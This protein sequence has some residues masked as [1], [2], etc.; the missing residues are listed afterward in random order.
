MLTEETVL[1]LAPNATFQPLG[2]N[3][4]AVVLMV[5]SGQLYTCND[6]TVALLQVLDGKRNFG[7]LIDAMLEEYE[8]ERDVLASDVREMLAELESEGIVTRVS[9]GA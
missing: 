5:D 3:E 4:G 2:E 7:A 8:V 9:A 6:T 1:A